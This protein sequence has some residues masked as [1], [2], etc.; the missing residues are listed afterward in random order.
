MACSS[1]ADPFQPGE[2]GRAAALT[3]PLSFGL[4]TE[5]GVL[6][7]RL[8]GLD[9]PDPDRARAALAALLGLAEAEA[10]GEA[11]AEAQGATVRLA[12]G[13]TRRDR[14]DRAL[15]QAWSMPPGGG[16]ER[17]LQAELVEAG[18]ARV[19][20]HADNRAGMAELLAIEARA[21]AAGRGLWSERQFA[22]RDPDP[23]ALAQDEGS[24]QLVEGRIV[25]ATRLRNGRLYLNF[26]SDYR[27]DFT[28]SVEAADMPAFEAAGLDAAMLESRRVRVRGWVE[29]DNGPMIRIDHPERIEV[30]ED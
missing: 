20:R 3:G 15:A 23:D 16:V 7:V 9:A 18:A 17:W 28:V 5:D 21:R 24:L 13:E 25:E 8:L 6:D 29:M 4:E 11:E 19:M 22:V 10:E 14:Y 2:T 27:T 12:Y 26:G 30:L 1:R